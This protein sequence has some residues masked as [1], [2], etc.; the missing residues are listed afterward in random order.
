MFP[1]KHVNNNF[2]D[3]ITKQ[4]MY[5]RL[6]TFTCLGYVIRLLHVLPEVKKI[7]FIDMVCNRAANKLHKPLYRYEKSCYH[8]IEIEIVKAI[9]CH[10]SFNEFLCERMAVD[11]STNKKMLKRRWLKVEKLISV[12]NVY[13]DNPFME[14]QEE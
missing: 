8:P 10:I 13:N 4:Q 12:Y 7:Q 1:T 6:N 3:R 11:S 9:A 2:I 5:E 14:D